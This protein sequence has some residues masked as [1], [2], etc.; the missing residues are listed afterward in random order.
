MR[1]KLFAI[2]MSMTM[3]ASFM[4]SLAFAAVTDHVLVL[5]PVGSATTVTWDAVQ[6]VLEDNEKAP[7]VNVVKEPTHTE[8]GKVE[9]TCKEDFCKEPVAYDIDKLGHDYVLTDLT[10][11][12]YAAKKLAAGLYANQKQ[13]DAFVKEKKAAGKCYVKNVKV[14]SC[15]D[16]QWDST[17]AYMGHVVKESCV[18]YHCDKCGETLKASHNFVKVTPAETVTTAPKSCKGSTAYKAV[19][20]KCQA[21]GVVY[22]GDPA[23]PHKYGSAV[24]VADATEKVVDTGAVKYEVKTG[25][26]A[27][28]KDYFVASKVTSPADDANV[29]IQ[30]G[31]LSA[32]NLDKYD[33]FKCNQEN[34]AAKCTDNSTFSLVCEECGVA[35]TEVTSSGHVYENVH[36][37]ATCDHPGQNV[38]TCKVC[39]YINGAPVDIATE[40]ALNHT[41]KVT[42]NAATCVT[43]ESYTIECTTCDKGCSAHKITLDLADMTSNAHVGSV[44]EDKTAKTKTFY[45][46]GFRDELTTNNAM[47]FVYDTTAR[48]NQH[49][50]G[51]EEVVKAATCTDDAIYGKKCKVCGKV[52]HSKVYAKTGT[53]LGHSYVESKVPATCGKYGKIVKTCST[54][55]D[56]T[57]KDDVNAK[58]LVKN[59]ANCTYDKWV[60][61]K[62]A[63]VFEEG[64][65]TLTCSVCGNEHESTKTVINKKSVAKASNTVK[66]GKK[67]FNVKSSAANATG[68]RV[69]YKKAGAKSWKSYTKKTTS[70]SKTFSGLSKGKYYVKVRAYAKNYDGD[71]QVVWG[72]TSSTKSVKV[73]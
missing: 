52:D 32:S 29:V 56:V 16:V 62:P 72:A 17:S 53:K 40:P 46:K 66:A 8:I 23:V 60:V 42:K 14:C 57:S 37:A 49:N 50:F 51:S 2:V 55:G 68:Y 3:V 7:Y 59:G 67:S 45:W 63:T 47:V 58:P 43:P 36:I 6:T 64:V 13:A 24:T 21:E 30:G 31:K 9:V 15:G 4:P 39:G 10:L 69:Y 27:I 35:A 11:E 61:T 22:E 28:K 54:C 38:A 33:F 1:K 65:K 26:V 18:D 70:L 5:K 25:Y 44:V 34:I 71:G 12:E 48:T 19:C 20:S 41:Y 73:K